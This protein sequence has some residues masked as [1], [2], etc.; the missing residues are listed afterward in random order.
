MEINQ[1]EIKKIL[2]DKKIE[3]GIEKNPQSLFQF[4][5]TAYK[6][7][8]KKHKLEVT[9]NKSKKQVQKERQNLKESLNDIFCDKV[10]VFQRTVLKS[11]PDWILELP[12]ERV[13]EG[14][15][16]QIRELILVDLNEQIKENIGGIS[17]I[18]EK[19]KWSESTNEE[20]LKSE[21]TSSL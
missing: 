7:W 14:C 16:Q 6:K 18:K 8:S 2:K 10:D 21:I 12:L 20:T 3:M 13:S 1:E 11:V 17:T 15:K 19:Y 4:L 9:L 5:F